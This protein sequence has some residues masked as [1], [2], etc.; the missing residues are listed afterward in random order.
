MALL[1]TD[2]RIGDPVGFLE[3]YPSLAR[4]PEEG[5]R[6]ISGPD[7]DVMVT[8]ISTEGEK[9]G[10]EYAPIKFLGNLYMSGQYF[11]KTIGGSQVNIRS[12]NSPQRMNELSVMFG[13]RP[14]EDV[15]RYVHAPEPGR[16]T[17]QLYTAHIAIGELLVGT[18]PQL[19]N[20]DIDSWSHDYNAHIPGAQ[21]MGARVTKAF[22][23]T[24]QSA[25]N[26]Q[27]LYELNE[28]LQPRP[29][30]K[31]AAV[32]ES[33]DFS[34]YVA[35]ILMKELSPVAS[36]IPIHPDNVMEFA[37]KG[38][39]KANIVPGIANE[40]WRPT[41]DLVAQNVEIIYGMLGRMSVLAPRVIEASLAVA[42]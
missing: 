35:T 39:Y 8:P 15:F 33:I 41:N 16:S 18:S 6:L 1:Y 38:K 7:L 24:A 11:G 31:E 42:A 32:A 37:R 36:M 12:F 19:T 30:N 40:I 22:M 21:I 28:L 2:E 23:E 3:A 29:L 4:L 13:L 34:T 5:Y 17:A 20:A 10:G 9:D 14:G 27:Q 25:P 26:S